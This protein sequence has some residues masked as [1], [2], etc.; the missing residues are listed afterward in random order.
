MNSSRKIIKKFIYKVLGESTYQKAY[1]K[2]K[3]SDIKSGNGRESEADFLK[4]FINKDSSVL[5]IGANYGHYTIEMAE[6]CPEGKVYSFE[7]V[8][9]TFEVLQKVTSYFKLKNINLFHNAVSDKKGEIEMTVPLLDFGAPNTGVAFIGTNDQVNSK[10]VKVNTLV[11]DDLEIQEQIDFIKIDIEGHEPNAFKGM[12]AL[13]KKNRPVILIEFSYPCLER[14]GSHPNDF[15]DY[16]QKELHYTFTTIVD[17]K[18]KVVSDKNPA[19][20]Y[21]FL[22]PTDK[23]DSFNKVLAI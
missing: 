8:P 2:G 15:S 11:L 20:G 23:L 13:I 9:F 19:D 4:Y 7:P 12:E 3:T 10:T 17:D 14:A 16:L 6:L 5:D 22:I 21:Y 1:V 18:L